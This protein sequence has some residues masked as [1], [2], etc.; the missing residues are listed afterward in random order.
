MF[1][2]LLGCWDV[3]VVLRPLR[4]GHP[5]LVAPGAWAASRLTV[6]MVTAYIDVGHFTSHER[7]PTRARCRSLERERPDRLFGGGLGGHAEDERGRQL[8]ILRSSVMIGSPFWESTDSMSRASSQFVDT[9][10]AVPSAAGLP[11]GTKNGIAIAALH[12]RWRW[13][14]RGGTSVADPELSAVIR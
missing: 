10:H 1:F 8:A 2:F 5:L 12:R 9:A 4:T 11:L 6:A 3:V 14:R 13:G 7:T